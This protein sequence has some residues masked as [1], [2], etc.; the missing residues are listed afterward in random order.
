V[1]A[2]IHATAPVAAQ[3]FGP[4]PTFF[5]LIQ[6]QPPDSYVRHLFGNGNELDQPRALD[7]GALDRIG[8]ELLQPSKVLD[9][10]T[11]RRRLRRAIEAHQSPTTATIVLGGGGRW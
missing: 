2:A 10:G 5:E 4:T 1:S 3:Y 7:P 6:E 8:A 11:S 9:P